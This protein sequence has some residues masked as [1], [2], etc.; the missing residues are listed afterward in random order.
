MYIYIYKPLV[1]KELT[2]APS[3]AGSGERQDYKKQDWFK[4]TIHRERNEGQ[5]K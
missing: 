5:I 3:M 1:P 2:A 4:D